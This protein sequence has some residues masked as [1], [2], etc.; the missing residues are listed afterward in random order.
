MMR[1]RPHELPVEGVRGVLAFAGELRPGDALHVPRGFPHAAQAAAGAPSLHLTV[2]MVKNAEWAE[3]L[4]AVL[5]AVD[6]ERVPPEQ[7]GLLRGLL[8]QALAAEASDPA[9]GWIRAALPPRYRRHRW[10]EQP[11]PRRILMV[12]PLHCS[13]VPRR[14]PLAAVVPAPHLALVHLRP[15][16][17]RTPIR[18]AARWSATE[19]RSDYCH[20]ANGIACP[21]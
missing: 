13:P 6:V 18:F 14:L 19:A 11:S 1:G 20:A 17:L 15:Q 5:A 9:A 3:V 2:S 21:D 7:Q 4:P 10:Y 16:A 12:L 8:P